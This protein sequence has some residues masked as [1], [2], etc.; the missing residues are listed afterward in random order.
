MPGAGRRQ[1]RMPEFVR[2][3][4][5]LPGQRGSISAGARKRTPAAPRPLKRPNPPPCLIPSCVP[6]H[7][8]GRFLRKRVTRPG[9]C[10]RDLRSS[11]YRRKRL[12]GKQEERGLGAAAAERRRP[13]ERH[14]ACGVKKGTGEA[15]G[16]RRDA[17]TGRPAARLS[18]FVSD[19]PREVGRVPWPMRRGRRR[20]PPRMQSCARAACKLAPH[21]ARQLS[22]DCAVRCGVSSAPSAG[23]SPSRPHDP[24]L[25]EDRQLTLV[26][27]CAGRC[28]TLPRTRARHMHRS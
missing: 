22:W 21:R 2:H 9:R 17:T 18:C 28:R 25:S 1:R 10:K 3:A 5:A 15:P 20:R 27:A 26:G 6:P 13:E 12:P 8:K 7:R 24:P 11:V 19:A 14:G 4:A 23:A 16:D